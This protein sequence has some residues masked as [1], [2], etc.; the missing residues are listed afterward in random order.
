MKNLL[1][2]LGGIFITLA[3]LMFMYGSIKTSRALDEEDKK[4]QLT[5][6]V[7]IIQESENK[8]KAKDSFKIG[9]TILVAGIILLV[10]SR[11]PKTI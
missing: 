11:K 10:M 7:V 1:G 2:L 3:I 5:D 4:I 9:G 8:D 6:E